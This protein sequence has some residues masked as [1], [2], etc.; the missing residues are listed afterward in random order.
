LCG[1]LLIGLSRPHVDSSCTLQHEDGRQECVPAAALVIC[2][3]AWPTSVARQA[4][5]D[6]VVCGV[7]QDPGGYDNMAICSGCDR[8]LHLRCVMPPMSTAPSGD[9]LCPGCDP[10]FVNVSELCDP[11]TILQYS[12]GDMHVDDFLLAY[13]RSGMQDSLLEGLP[14][15]RVRAIRHRAAAL[16]PQRTLQDWLLVLR[17]VKGA[18]PKWLC[19]PPVSYRWDLIR[20]M[21]DALGHAGVQQTCAYMQQHFHWRGLPS[22]V[23]LYLAQCDACQRRRLVL[24]APFPMQEP[25]ICGPF[26]HVHVDL[27]GPFVTPCADLHGRLYLPQPHHRS[28]SRP[29][30]L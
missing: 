30:L 12:Q 27:C 22:D 11:D 24:P 16:R 25:I 10:W 21:H 14:R 28:R 9:W 6:S 19:C 13:V 15:G 29:G 1:R 5:Y 17:H 8:C 26:E 2:S 23:K 4:H 7:C 20:C 3:A 18:S